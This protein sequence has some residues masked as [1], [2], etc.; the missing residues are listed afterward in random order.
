MKKE[1]L[2]VARTG[3][4]EFSDSTISI[5]YNIYLKVMDI[6]RNLYMHKYSV[7]IG[8][9]TCWRSLIRFSPSYSI[10]WSTLFVFDGRDRIESAHT[11]CQDL[12]AH[13]KVCQLSSMYV[14][15]RIWK[16]AFS[17]FSVVFFILIAGWLVDFN[18]SLL[19]RKSIIDFSSTFE[20]SDFNVLI[21]FLCRSRLLS[22]KKKKI[23]SKISYSSP[24]PKSHS[25]AFSSL[26]VDESGR[27][28]FHG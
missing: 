27:A 15:S 24:R 23:T 4:W 3:K 26:S 1:T 10:V 20:R 7:S 6:I 25:R 22:T 17:S 18:L 21:F 28:H 14:T 8:N 9:E 11:N 19:P 12:T 13:K 16:F 5:A 2:L